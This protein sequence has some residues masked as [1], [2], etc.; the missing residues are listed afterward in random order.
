LKRVSCTGAGQQVRYVWTGL[1]QTGP[2]RAEPLQTPDLAEQA[3]ETS[4]SRSQ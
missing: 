2:R 4:D 3:G 1:D